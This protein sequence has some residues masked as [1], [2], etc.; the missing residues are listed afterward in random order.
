M[1]LEH[2]HKNK[3]N[4]VYTKSVA[5]TVAQAG[6]WEMEA[7][8]TLWVETTLVYKVSSRTAKATVSE[9]LSQSQTNKTKEVWGKHPVDQ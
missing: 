9:T 2:Y 4:Y 3:Q 5:A 6:V 1:S 8:R 7:G